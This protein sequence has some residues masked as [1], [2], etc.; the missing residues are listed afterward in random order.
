MRII[1]LL[2]LLSSS[3]SFFFLVPFKE[4]KEIKVFENK[5]NNLENIIEDSI[6][7]VCK[8]E[9]NTNFDDSLVSI[10]EV[11]IKIHESRKWV[12]NLLNASLNLTNYISDKY[13]KRFYSSIFIKNS[14]NQTCKL[15]A[16]L[17]ISGDGKDHIELTE[18]GNIIS[19]LDVRL[20]KGNI[21]G[22]TNFKLF[23]PKSRK[24]SSEVITALLLK[25]M[26]HL[27][28]RTKMIRVKVNNQSQEMIF[29][30]KP[31]KEMLENNNLRESAI[32]QTDQTLLWNLRS[33]HISRNGNFANTVFPKIVNIKWVN[34][35]PVSQ[36][37][38]LNGA[39]LFSKV[40][41]ESWNR[42]GDH[43]DFS[44]SDELLSNGNIINRKKLSQFKA[45]LIA[46]GAGHAL[47]NANRKFYF[48]PIEN[49]FLP[50]YYD[51][52]ADIR[53]LSDFEVYTKEF[54]DAYMTRDIKAEDFDYVINQ[55]ENIN[56]KN[57][58]DKLNYSGVNI[59]ISELINIK[60]NIIKNL[61]FLK[62]KHIISLNYQFTKN[63]FN[64]QS[65]NFVNYG[66]VFYSHDDTFFSCNF[67][68]EECQKVL[69]NNTDRN[70]LLNGEYAKGK[71]QY[72][73]LGDIFNP[74]TKKYNEGIIY[75][76]NT[77][78]I[79]LYENIYIKKYGEPNIKVDKKKRLI[80]IEVNN[81]NEKVLFIDSKLEDWE[82]N[83]N[84][85]KNK[86]LQKN[87]SRFDKNLLTS[88]LTIK[89]SY[90]SGIKISI[91][92]G[93][94]EDS[95][96][97]ISSNGDI[98]SINIKDSFQDAIDFD[99]SNLKVNNISVKNAGN[100]CLDISSG[101]YFV[102]NITLE[103]CLDKGVSAGE[104]STLQLNNAKIKDTKIALV[105]KD[106]SKLVL[107]KGKLLNNLI[108]AAVYNKKQEFGPSFI[109]IPPKLC[110]EDQLAIQTLSRIQIK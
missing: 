9:F 105:S 29:Q 82:I 88:L 20:T 60:N 87:I 5:N 107:K 104:K 48:D 45:I 52:M 36:K 19:S 16:K 67:E 55:I 79:N 108:C 62:E 44:Y 110:P 72:Y 39:N 93:N 12:K 18:D 54:E 31:R 3:F 40:I 98:D 24:G 102:N 65:S 90:I 27:S 77:P 30:E 6:T 7:P 100:D 64:R 38:G 10:N 75:G 46:S 35:N 68:N 50:I 59:E 11:D 106:N 80:S 1:Y 74:I 8:N 2:F 96:N 13:K 95:L 61:I 66:L 15:N 109:S 28:P 41:L 81:P 17:R 89:D 84:T 26:G 43:Q 58:I 76:T 4:K 47:H 85:R 33:N 86:D 49:S 51:G 34:R 101:K 99:F 69:M 92:G 97:I 71:K 63:P 14:N 22:I 42:G 103:G 56:L 32:L 23:L 21:N 78:T 91:Q 37:I 83:V 53:N 70:K 25:E 94:D 57:F 73:F